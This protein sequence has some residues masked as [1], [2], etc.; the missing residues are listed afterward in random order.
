[1][2][3]NLCPRS[4]TKPGGYT[5]RRYRIMSERIIP[6]VA[7]QHISIEFPKIVVYMKRTDRRAR[8]NLKRNS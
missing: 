4:N 3:E 5:T 6:A 2:K 8:P 1:M 7:P